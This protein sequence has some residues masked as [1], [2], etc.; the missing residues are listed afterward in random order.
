MAEFILSNW[1]ELILGLI[2]FLDVVVSI[3]PSKT[4]D[5][6]L[7]YFRLLFNAITSQKKK[8]N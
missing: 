2:A 1:A 4:D 8:K 7:G 3:T 5:R 6:L